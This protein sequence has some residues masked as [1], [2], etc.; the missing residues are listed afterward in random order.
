[1]S[2]PL[3]SSPSFLPFRVLAG[4]TGLGLARGDPGPPPFSP[5]SRSVMRRALARHPPVLAFGSCG[6]PYAT[7]VAPEGAH[8]HG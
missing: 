4:L 2:S 1:M 7:K 3:G 5:L 8:C 6:T